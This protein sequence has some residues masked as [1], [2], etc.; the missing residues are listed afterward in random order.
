[1]ENNHNTQHRKT[2]AW[3]KYSVRQVVAIL[4]TVLMM[5]SSAATAMAVSVPTM[6]TVVDGDTTHTVWMNG[7]DTQEILDLAGITVGDQDRIVR[8]EKRRC[9]HYSEAGDSNSRSSRWKN[10]KCTVLYW[11]QHRFCFGAGRHCAGGK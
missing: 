9:N 1:M 3:V 2:K 8:E 5:G 4:A 6:T 10:H 7:T 11:R